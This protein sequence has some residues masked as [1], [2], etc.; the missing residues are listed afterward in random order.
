MQQAMVR[1][2]TAAMEQVRADLAMLVAARDH[3]VLVAEMA[4]L[5]LEVAGHRLV[6]A[7]RVRAHEAAAPDQMAIDALAL[8]KIDDE[9][10]GTTN[11]A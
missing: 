2:D 1:D 9:V 10:E 4:M 8:D 3:H 7:G 6:V 11:L 5:E